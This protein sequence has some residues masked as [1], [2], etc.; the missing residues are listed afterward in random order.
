M[1]NAITFAYDVH[2][3]QVSGAPA[4]MATERFDMAI[5]PGTPGQPNGRQLRRLLQKVLT[6]RFQLAFHNE[7]RELSV[8]A[9]TQPALNAAVVYYGSSPSDPA[10]YAKIKAPVLGLYGGNDA[11]VNATIPTAQENMKG[12]VYEAHTFEGA[13]HGFLR[14][15]NGANGANMKATEQAWPLTLEFLRKHT[16]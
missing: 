15:Q 7:K 6:E 9:I 14:Q 1:L 2:E 10:A 3:R 8:Y 5:K 16:R 12:K 11:R 4:W 13:G